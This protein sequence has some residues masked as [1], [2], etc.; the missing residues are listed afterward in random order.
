MTPK[1]MEKRSFLTKIRNIS[2]GHFRLTFVWMLL[3]IR[4]GASFAIHEWLV[5]L[6]YGKNI[7]TVFTFQTSPADIQQIQEVLDC[8]KQLK[9]SN[10]ITRGKRG[11][12]QVSQEMHNLLSVN[13]TW[14]EIKKNVFY[15]KLIEKNKHVF[16]SYLK[17]PFT[18]VNLNAWKTKPNMEVAH[19]SYGTARGP[20]RLHKDGMPAGHFKCMIYLKPLND[21]YGKVQ[22]G[23]E[24]YESE[25]P[26]FSLVFNT[27][28]WHQSIPGSSKDRYV[29]ELTLMRTLVDV[30]ILKYYPGTP[31]TIHLLQA[32]QAYI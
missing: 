10:H 19:D 22:I 1:E 31:N 26:G 3:F 25:K 18:V 7:P 24:I 29:L 2:F 14:F 9:Q 15:D 13:Q 32:Y 11:N 12:Q 16:R 17:S 5:S 30:D 4:R 23:K 20:N 21:S 28:Q 6:F 8:S 27:E